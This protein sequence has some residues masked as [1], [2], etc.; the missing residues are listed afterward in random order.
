MSAGCLDDDVDDDDAPHAFD[1][2]ACL[3]YVLDATA[4]AIARGALLLN[5][6]VCVRLLVCFGMSVA[7]PGLGWIR[8]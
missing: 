1:H 3:Q 6:A 2:P 8:N 5:C 4:F 7:S